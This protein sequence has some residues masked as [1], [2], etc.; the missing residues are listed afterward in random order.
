MC[1]H[2]VRIG[3]IVRTL[4]RRIAW[5][6]A[7]LA[8]RARVSQQ[9]ISLIETGRRR[10]LSIDTLER[11]LAE[12]EAEV[13]VVVRWRGGEID[14]VTDEGHATLVGE[15]IRRLLALGWE[16]QAEVTY[17]I[18]RSHGSIDVFAHR[19]DQQ[20]LLICEIKSEFT[21]AEYTLR[22]HDEKARLGAAIARQRFG[23]SV[24][25]VSRLLVLPDSTTARRRVEGHDALLHPAYPL[26]GR[27]LVAWLRD[28][29]SEARGILFLPA[30]NRP[31]GSRDLTSRRRIMR[32]SSRPR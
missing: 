6:Q 14:R 15:V 17:S 8:L 30:T 18:G 32:R 24:S 4:R 26:R 9:A 10:R 7:D 23:W 19:S 20:A 22:K 12:L 16:V 5:R 25:S 21:S 2:P 28:P 13:E 1:V 31:G 3:R 11:V 27:E 29:I